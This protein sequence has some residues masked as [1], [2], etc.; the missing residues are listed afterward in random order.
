MR[1]L[2]S[3]SSPK[4]GEGWGGE[5]DGFGGCQNALCNF[6]VSPENP[7]FLVL[8]EA[9]GWRQTEAAWESSKFK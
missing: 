3:L 2:F 7:D 9:S 8:F 5:A 6:F 1:T 4:G